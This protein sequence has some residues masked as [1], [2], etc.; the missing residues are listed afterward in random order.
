MSR[1]DP[2][3][4]VQEQMLR[5]RMIGRTCSIRCWPNRV[6]LGEAVHKGVA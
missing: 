2:E 4:N 6:Y 5:P 3:V 1:P